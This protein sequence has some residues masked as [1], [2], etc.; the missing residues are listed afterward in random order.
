MC[1]AFLQH[2]QTQ[3]DCVGAPKQCADRAPQELTRAPLLR[4]AYKAEGRGFPSRPRLRSGRWATDAGMGQQRPFQP[5]RPR[6][7]GSTA[8]SLKRTMCA[9][10]LGPLCWRQRRAGGPRRRAPYRSQPR[11][12]RRRLG[13]SQKAE[14]GNGMLPSDQRVLATLGRARRLPQCHRQH[15]HQRLKVHLR[16]RQPKFL[17]YHLRSLIRWHAT[18]LLSD[19]VFR[20]HRQRLPFPLAA[21]LI[22]VVVVVHVVAVA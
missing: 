3:G 18:Q 1:A 16:N 10:A 11:S 2:G 15:H 20:K 19:A 8:L 9:A 22:A 7:C 4:S 17:P 13:W 12:K 14:G 6:P 5:P 21:H